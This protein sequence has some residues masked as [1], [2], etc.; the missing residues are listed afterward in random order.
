MTAQRIYRA[1]SPY[2]DVELSEIDYVQSNDVLY[3]A[4]WDHAPGKLSRYG[5]T[6]W[7]FTTVTFGPSI[8]APT[9]LVATPASPNVT[10]GLHV[11]DA[12]YIVTATDLVTGQESRGSATVSAS[13]DLSLKSNTNTITW[14]AVTG[15]EYYTIYKSDSG[16]LALHGYIGSTTGL[17]FID[18]NINGDETDTP[19]QGKNP[20]D[21]AGNWPSTVALYDSRLVWGRTRNKPNVI[22]AS[23]TAS[24]ENMDVSRPQ[25]PDDAF[26]GGLVAER[27]NAVNQLIPMTDLLAL[28]SDGL[29]KIFPG[30]TG[31]LASRRQ[32]GDGSSRTSLPA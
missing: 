20:M 1:P 7:T 4:H 11:E 12:T 30:D 23:Q 8:S 28:C 26:T 21:V 24:Y 9:G 22:Y 17:S 29:F 32:A 13:N 10:G 31:G 14:S 16:A 2:N 6:D 27:V 19:P 3:L 5:H 15:A 25:R 18:N